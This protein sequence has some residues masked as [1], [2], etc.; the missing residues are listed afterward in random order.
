MPATTTIICD[1]CERPIEA[2]QGISHPALFVNYSHPIY[3]GAGMYYCI[4]AGCADNMIKSLH[5]APAQ[6]MLPVEH[7]PEE[8]TQTQEAAPAPAEEPSAQ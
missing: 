4:E 8:D 2:V 6:E 1:M 5:G 7:K 3:G